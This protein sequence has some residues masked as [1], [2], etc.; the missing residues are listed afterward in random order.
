[1][2]SKSY[3][4]PSNHR[5]MPITCHISVRKIDKMLKH[6][7]KNQ[8]RT[9]VLWSEASYNLTSEWF[10]II[11]DIPDD[12]GKFIQ[13]GTYR[14]FSRGSEQIEFVNYANKF[15][16]VIKFTTIRFLL[17]ILAHVDLQLHQMWSQYFW[18]VTWRRR[19][20][21]EGVQ[22]QAMDTKGW[23]REGERRQV[24]ADWE[25]GM[26]RDSLNDKS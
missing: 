14:L 12:N 19:F 20:V 3:Q 24:R 6:Q 23:R 1:M 16:L 11:N 9:L 13:R 17:A 21:W 18:T 7:L 2:E 26:K 4:N 25:W 5:F 10:F 22:G 15:P 8:T